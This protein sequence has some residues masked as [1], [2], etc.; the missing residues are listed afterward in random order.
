M[1]ETSQRDLLHD[2]AF[3][4]LHDSQATNAALIAPLWR[5]ADRERATTELIRE[6]IGMLLSGPYAPSEHALLK[7]LYPDS[8]DVERLAQSYADEREGKTS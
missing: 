2:I 3:Q 5:S 6:R 4:M 1:T 8:R 7:A